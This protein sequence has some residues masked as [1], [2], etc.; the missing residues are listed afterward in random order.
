MARLCILVGLPGSGKSTYAKTVKKNNVI[1]S[2]DEIREILY[3]NADIQDDPAKVFAYVDSITYDCLKYGM[4]VIYD[5]TSLT[6]ELRSNI[7]KKFSSV[8]SSISCVYMDTPVE[9][10]IARQKTRDRVVPTEVILEMAE[11]LEI[12]EL[13][14]GF[15]S[16]SKLR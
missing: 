16:V 15:S 13:E 1:V 3:G 12:P 4:D 9:T 11:R 2:S 8:A 14:E 5:A 7:L 10:C 6:K